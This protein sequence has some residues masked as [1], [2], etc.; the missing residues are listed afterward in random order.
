MKK[1]RR[2]AREGALQALFQIEM[3]HA[4]VTEAI[5][6]TVIETGVSHDLADYMEQLVRGIYAD[7][8]QLDPYIEGFLNGY[9]LERLAAVDR[10]VIRI[11]TYELLK[12]PEMPPAVTINE[13][14]EIAKRFST[15]ESGKFV[16][17]VLGR[18]LQ[19][20][21]KKNWTRE[22]APPGFEEEE[23]APEPVEEVE[24]E[25]VAEDSKEAKD[26][27]RFGWV[28]KSGDREIPKVEGD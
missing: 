3:G 19:D 25:T 7:R 12:V 15:A 9:E 16:N 27:K 6:H 18:I 10:N 13:A 20:S 8:R 2:K 22:T 23:A 24:E 17:G 11:G 21:P 26:A 1:S 28:L 5:E 4:V 14:V